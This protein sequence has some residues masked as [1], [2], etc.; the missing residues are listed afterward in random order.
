MRSMRK[1]SWSLFFGLTLLFCAAAFGD[2]VEDDTVPD[3]TARVSRISLIR[4][5]VQIRREGSQDW[6]KAVLNLPIVEGDEVT[7]G[8]DGRL[9]IQLNLYSHIRVAEGSYLK[10]VG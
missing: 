4:G 9:E 8:L 2:D 5:D 6:E 3:V 7:T 1:V 10:V